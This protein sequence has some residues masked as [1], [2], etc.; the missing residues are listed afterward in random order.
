MD[1]LLAQNKAIATQ[2]AAL[3]KKVEASQ[4][5]VVQAQAP[6]QEEDASE[7]ECE[8][9]QANYVNN[10]SR[11][12]YDSNSKT[13][14]PGWK[15]H[16][17]F[18]RENQQDHKPYHS[19]HHNN[20]NTNHQSRN[21]RPYHSS[22]NTSHHPT[23]QTHNS[24]H[25]DTSTPTM[26]LCET[27]NSFSKLEAAIAQL[28]T[29]LTR[30][31]S[32]ILERQLQADRKIDANQEEAGSNIKNQR[33]AISK[34]KAQLGSLSKQISMSIHTFSS[35]TVANP[36]GECKA[37]KLRSGKVVEE[38]T[39]SQ[40][41]QEEEIA[42]EHKI[43]KE[44][45]TSAPSSP[46]QVLKPYVPQAPYTQRL[47]K[48]EK[49]SQFSRFLEIF[50]KLQI[51]IPFA[52]A[53]EQTPFYAKFLK[54]LMK[55]KRNWGE[56]ETIVLTEE[57]SVIIQ[58]KLPQ[59]LKDPGSFQI[60]CIIGNMNIEKALYDLE[61]SINLMSLAMMKIMRIEEAKPTRMALQLA[62]ITFKFSHGVVEDLL[63]KV[64]EF[65][66]LA[67]FV[68]LDMEEEVKTSII[69]GRPFLATAR[70]II[71]VQKGEL[72]LRLH[73]AK[74]VFNVIKEMSYPKEAIS[75]CMM[76]DTIEN[77]VQRVIEEEQYEETQEQD[78]Q[79]SCG[80]LPLEAMDKSIMMDKP[81]KR[82]LK[83]PKLELKI[84]PPSLK[85]SYLGDNNTYPVIISSNLNEE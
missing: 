57:C 19:N 40:S 75:E 84:L 41:H 47:R 54:E 25:Q 70:A 66:F 34:L 56:K 7:V 83:A 3:T 81:S 69:L 24:H 67:D 31:I 50:K 8:W 42:K 46:K 27:S 53:L 37:I 38:T 45:N 74:M 22:Q 14:N 11:P 61:A 58:K 80:E 85:Y 15:N 26:Q 68:V 60:P 63:L 32:T 76:V 48:D 20:H 71:D 51:I 43:K 30:T 1:T 29:Q 49:D 55:R 12:V 72:V 21:N 77:M 59:K 44:E 35:D 36:R 64:G 52:E 62:D 10:P 39:P 65:I 9:E 13:Y 18:R 23:Q 79:V 28:S 2:L 16:P 33:A 78:Q 6:P 5:S 4:V 82:K 17:N 73:E